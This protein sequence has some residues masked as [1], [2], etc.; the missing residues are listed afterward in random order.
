MIRSMER[1]GPLATGA[2][3]CAVTLVVLL[4][5]RNRGRSTLP[6]KSFSAARGAFVVLTVLVLGVLWTI[7]G[8]ALTDTKLN[9]VNFIVLPITFGIGCEYPFNVY[10]RSRILGGD[11]S[12]AVQRTGGAVALCSY[13]TVVGYGSLLFNDFQSLQSFGRLAMTGEVACLSGALFV[14]PAML[15]ILQTGREHRSGDPA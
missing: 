14:L 10:D 15:H 4:A 3:F 2:S 5:T 9:F 11:V 7:G 1:D 6:G 12:L 13:T 8:A